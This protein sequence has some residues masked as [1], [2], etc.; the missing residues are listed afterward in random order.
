MIELTTVVPSKK[1]GRKAAAPA[2]PVVAPVVYKGRSGYGLTD[3]EAAHIGAV[4][5]AIT[6]RDGALT[7]EALVDEA[8]PLT[9]PAHKHFTWDDG[10][11]AEAYRR[12]EARHLIRGI[13]IVKVAPPSAP[14]PTIVVPAFESVTSAGERGYQPLAEV[15]AQPSLLAQVEPRLIADL[16]QLRARYAAYISMAEWAHLRGFWAGIDAIIAGGVTTKT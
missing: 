11:A 14:M 9:S 5:D 10:L 16:T 7:P 15:M 3:A 1:K 12:E 2:A 13:V 6:K 4:L 8:R